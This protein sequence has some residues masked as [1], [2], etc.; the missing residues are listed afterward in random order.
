MIAVFK[1]GE[2]VG[3]IPQ[4]FSKTT[5]FFLRYEEITGKR[6]NRSIQLGVEVPCLYKF[7]GHLAKLKELVCQGHKAQ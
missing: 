2:V 4:V 3:H 7:Y 1:D 6:L 5:L